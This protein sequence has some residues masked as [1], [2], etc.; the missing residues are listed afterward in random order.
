MPVYAECCLL[1]RFHYT[2]KVKI[3]Q[4]V[5]HHAIDIFKTL[6]TVNYSARYGS[7]VA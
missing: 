1:P 4:I 5:G 3:A 2:V 7:M 6:H